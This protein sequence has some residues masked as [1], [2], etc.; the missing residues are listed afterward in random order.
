MV[1][2]LVVVTFPLEPVPTHVCVARGGN[3]YV[4]GTA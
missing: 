3:V 4:V 2:S 1:A